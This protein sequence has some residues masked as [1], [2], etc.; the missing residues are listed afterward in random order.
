MRSSNLNLKELNIACIYPA[1]LSGWRGTTAGLKNMLHI[2]KGLGLKTDLI[3]YHHYSNKFRIEHE[4]INPLLNSTTIH[5][6]SYLG[7]LKVFSIFL[8][9]I[10]AWNPIRK[11]DIIFAHVDVLSGIP[12][13]ILGRIFGKSVIL[14]YIDE[15]QN[16][17]LHSINKYIL[18]KVDIVFAISYYLIDKAKR[19]GCENIVYLPAFVDTNL[20]KV[21]MN[22]R[23]KIRDDFKIEDNDIVIGYAGTFSY[24]EGVSNL[25]RAFANL[26]KRYSNTKMI[27]MGKMGKNYEDI[28][29]YVRDLNL[30]DKVTLLPPQPHED[31]PRF[32]SACDITCCSKIDCEINRAAHPIKVVE[33]LS[34]GLPTVC[35]SVGGI[36]YT[37]K[38]GV[39]G[40]LVK[41]GDVKDLEE[42]LEWIILNPE[43]SKAIGEN[44][45][46]KVIGKYSFEAIENTIK[47]SIK[48]II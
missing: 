38:D 4:N 13:V 40:F 18:K 30:K 16:P 8:G 37:I 20:F 9:F 6:P 26:S 41:P 47:E 3:S 15:E 19:Y 1:S 27:V 5:L 24:F 36:T 31:V 45:R 35:S 7:L 34:M 28:P 22:A 23:K 11:C 44:G 25:L 32:L 39:D 42:K 33:Y 21:D 2:F 12:A 43:R 46:K 14:H 17:I 29:K 48:E 10:Y